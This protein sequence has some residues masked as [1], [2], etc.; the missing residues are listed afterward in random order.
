MTNDQAVH[1]HG[2]VAARAALSKSDEAASA[3]L[4]KRSSVPFFAISMDS[5]DQGLY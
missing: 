4:P 2:V 3:A 5:G 1:D